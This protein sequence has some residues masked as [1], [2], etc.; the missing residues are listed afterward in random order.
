[1]NFIEAAAQVPGLATERHAQ[2]MYGLC[3]WLGVRKA[4][5]VG[6]YK[7]KCSVWI[8]RAIQDNGGGLLSIIDDFSLEPRTEAVLTASLEACGVSHTCEIVRADSQ[9]LGAFPECEFAFIDGD[10]SLE[11]CKRDA[12]KAR[13]AGARCI[14]FHDT[15]AW[16][17]PRDF[18][19][20][21]R[22]GKCAWN[23][24][25][26]DVLEANH[27]EGFSVLLRREPKPDVKYSQERCPDG[28]I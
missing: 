19:A 18:I 22:K 14:A 3:R 9:K 26:W 4:V 13:D 1:M 17:G 20:M 11:G 7:G 5:E 21:V 12:E 27:D 10:H 25:N 2:L 24:G 6:A 8:A 28:C 23:T 16:W 15:H